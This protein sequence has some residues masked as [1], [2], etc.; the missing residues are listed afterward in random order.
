MSSPAVMVSLAR[1]LRLAGAQ[2]PFRSDR[3]TSELLD[4]AADTLLEAYR[5]GAEEAQGAI[6][7]RLQRLSP[8]AEPISVRPNATTEPGGAAGI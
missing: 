5:I 6:L 2:L 7:E 1:V 3:A 8:P 4:H